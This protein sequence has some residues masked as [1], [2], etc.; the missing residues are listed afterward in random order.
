MKKIK[1]SLGSKT[2]RSIE[3]QVS[4]ILQSLHAGAIEISPM[5]DRDWGHRAAYSLDPDGHLLAFAEEII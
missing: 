4:T 3:F 5:A 1:L 2:L